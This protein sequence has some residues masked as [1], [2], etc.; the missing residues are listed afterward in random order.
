MAMCFD[1]MARVAVKY[2]AGDF[3]RITGN[4]QAHRTENAN[5]KK[6]TAQNVVVNGID[7]AESRIE[8]EY[9]IKGSG[10][11]DKINEVHIMGIVTGISDRGKDMKCIGIRTMRGG[12]VSHLILKAYVRPSNKEILESIK[13]GDNICTIG[14]IQTN[15]RK[16]RLAE[17]LQQAGGLPGKPKNKLKPGSESDGHTNEGRKRPASGTMYFENLIAMEISILDKEKQTSGL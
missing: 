5:G 8:A 12:N 17:G 4:M 2:K 11:Y 3:V 6:I 9:G 10:L 13:R 14:T 15:A 7:A 1:G 16:S